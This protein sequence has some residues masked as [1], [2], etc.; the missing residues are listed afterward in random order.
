VAQELNARVDVAGEDPHA[1]ALAWM[2]EER[3]VREG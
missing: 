1:V 2:T 3:F